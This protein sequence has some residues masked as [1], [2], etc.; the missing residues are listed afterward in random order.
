MADTVAPTPT[1]VR[2]Q[3]VGGHRWRAPALA[4]VR[5]RWFGVTARAVVGAG[6]LAA[7]VARVGTGPFLHGVQSLD[8]GT[9]GAAIVLAAIATAAAAWRW[10]VIAR[11]LGVGL[12]WS[13]AVGMYYRSQFLNT[14]LPGGVI[15]D[16][17]RAV[18]H[19]RSAE[20]LGTAA[21]AVA[22]ERS[23]GQVVQVA[24]T[25]LVIVAGGAAFGTAGATAGGV[26]AG[27][28]DFG[29]VVFP[30]LGIGA[31]VVVLAATIAAVASARVR[32]VLRREAAQLRVGLGSPAVAAQAIGASVVVCCC[33]IATFAIATAAVGAEVPPVRMLVLAVVVL[34]AA[35]IPLNLG[36][37]GPREG[38]AG[39]AFAVA[40]FGTAAGVSAATLFGVLAIVSLVPGVL[41]TMLAT[42]VQRRKRP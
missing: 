27:A 35:A 23:V 29:G 30:A 10:T 8:A 18:D 41:G 4:V 14:V 26:D 5:S 28:A 2:G 37:W 20:R 42:I 19:G 11:R 7:I 24:I 9:V 33:H 3:V 13:R 1:T 25:V 12:P 38:A 34:L 15:G 40:G 39:W 16:V 17:H 22:V 36:G 6:V 21:R 32:N 31:A